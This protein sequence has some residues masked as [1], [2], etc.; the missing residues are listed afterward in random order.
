VLKHTLEEFNQGKLTRAGL[1]SAIKLAF[2]RLDDLIPFDRGGTTATVC[3]KIGNELWTANVGDSRAVLQI[4]DQALQL[5]E[6]AVPLDPRYL[7]NI[8]LRGGT[9]IAGRVGGNLEVARSIGDKYMKEIMN[10]R[11]KVTVFPLDRIPP[12]SHLI[13]GCDG[14][15]A[16]ASTKQVC[17]IAHQLQG[18]EPMEIAET[19]SESALANGSGDNISALVVR[20]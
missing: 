12:G 2:V 8:E 16:K 11:P 1:L 7:K 17:D 4:G 18:K 9:I 13:L 19:L 3:M 20:F 14:Q 10:P 5:T 15:F 6:D